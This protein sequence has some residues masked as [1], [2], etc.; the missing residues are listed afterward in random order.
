MVNGAHVLCLQALLQ[1]AQGSVCATVCHASTVAPALTW[2]TVT[3]VHVQP[4]SLVS[5]LSV[6]FALC[7]I[8]YLT[9]LYGILFCPFNSCNLSVLLGN[10]RISLSQCEIVVNSVIL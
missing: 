2:V 8:S 10:F 9:Q 6:S 7:Y 4:A 5:E 3:T 1:I